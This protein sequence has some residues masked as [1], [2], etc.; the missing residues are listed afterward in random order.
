MKNVTVTGYVEGTGFVGGIV[1]YG[2]NASITGCTNA[3]TVKGGSS[4]VGGIVGYFFSDGNVR[5]CSN[6]GSVRAQINSDQGM[7]KVGGIAGGLGDHDVTIA[8]CYNAGSMAIQDSGTGEYGVS[9]LG[10]IVGRTLMSMEP[11]IYPTATVRAR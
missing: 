11:T 5:N 8:D 3:A 6:L 10:G 7:A 4:N 2:N 9:Y 1:G